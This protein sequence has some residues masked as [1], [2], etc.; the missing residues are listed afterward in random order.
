MEH[1]FQGNIAYM[2]LVHVY[3]LSCMRYFLSFSFPLDVG[4][5]LKLVCLVLFLFSVALWFILGG[6]SCFKVLPCS[7][8]TLSSVITSVGEEGADLCAS[9]AFVLTM[10]VFVLFLFFWCRGLAAVCDSGTP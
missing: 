2:L 5:W 1:C 7:L 9:R 8:H 6:V 4:G 3:V 10:L